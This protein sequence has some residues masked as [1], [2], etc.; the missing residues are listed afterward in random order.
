MPVN[1]LV[2]TGVLACAGGKPGGGGPG[3]T[4]GDGETGGR[5]G[6]TGGTAGRATGGSSGTGGAGT[7][8]APDGS[9]GTGGAGAGDAGPAVPDAGMD[10][11]G[12]ASPLRIFWI[13]TEGGAATLL[14]APDGQTLL[15]DAGWAGARDP[16]RIA[17]VLAQVGAKK[18]D[19]LLATHFHE[20]HTGGM[21]NLVKLVPAVT[22][23]DHGNTVEP[24]D[25]GYALYTSALGSSARRMS[26]KAGDKLQLGGVE[27]IFVSS[28]GQVTAPLAGAAANPACA[29]A[30]T[31]RDVPD[32]DPRSVGFLARYGTFEFVDLGDLTWEVEGQLAC[33]MNRLGPVDLF[34]SSQHGTDDSNARQLVHGLAPQVIVVN[35]GA[36]KG[37]G[38]ES[39]ETFQSSPGIKDIWQVHRVT[40][41]D[42]AHNTDEALTANVAATDFN[43]SAT[44]NADGSFTVS[45]GRTQQ[46]RSYQA[47]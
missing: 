23:V 33:P 6:A 16:G 18:I 42:A 46:S 22:F 44:V 26:V 27:I 29:G 12:A 43:L 9:A 10:A 47:R 5:Q 38:T 24:S 32:E 1:L 28:H 17:A 13:D 8:G 14:V 15:A 31:K 21:A 45:N 40:R 25:P 37:G 4:G 35:C 20:D 19:Y 36:G 11:P 2:L 39:F 41:L 3:G 7:G 34:Q 30:R